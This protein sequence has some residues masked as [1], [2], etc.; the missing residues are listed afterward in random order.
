MDVSLMNEGCYGQKLCY[1]ESDG[2]IPGCDGDDCAG[3]LE[4][5]ICGL[6]WGPGYGRLSRN[7]MIRCR[8]SKARGSS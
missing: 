7:L 2:C 5:S 3:W 1:S 8:V 6:H 4:V